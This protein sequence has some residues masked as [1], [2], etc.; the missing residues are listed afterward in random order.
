MQRER[1]KLNQAGMSLVELI[2]VILILGILSAGTA[3]GINY[4]S[5]M[6]STSAAEKLVSLMERTRLYTISTEEASSEEDSEEDAK[7]V[8]LVLSKEGDNYYGTL[9]YD[10]TEVDKVEL[11]NKSLTIKV[12][13]KVL[14]GDGD[15]VDD[16]HTIVD[17]SGG[18][19]VISYEKANG[20][21]KEKY[22]QIEISGSE[23]RYIQMVY[24]T[25]RSYLK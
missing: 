21:F 19:Y 8:S 4:A 6:N 5:R 1:R 11:G 23:T 20:A 7:K 9:M 12:T 13:K 15:E 14:N 17:G 22:K 2:V 16:T 3:V 25:G 24:T 18:S 10:T